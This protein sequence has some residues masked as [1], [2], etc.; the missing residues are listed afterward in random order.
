MALS[1]NNNKRMTV[2][3]R[4]CISF[5]ELFP[6]QETFSALVVSVSVFKIKR[7]LKERLLGKKN[8]IKN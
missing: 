5:S 2:W 7:S 4:I 6:C 1:I 3:L 8:F